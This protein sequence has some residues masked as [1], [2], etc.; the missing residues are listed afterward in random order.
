MAFITTKQ[1]SAPTSQQLINQ[2]HATENLK[3]NPLSGKISVFKKVFVEDNPE[4][5][6]AL[7]VLRRIKQ[8]F[9]KTKVEEVRI[10]VGKHGRDSAASKAAKKQKLEVVTWAGT[11][12]ER[13]NDSLQNHSGLVAIDLDKVPDIKA[14]K[15]KLSASQ[16]VASCWTSS[17]ET[18][19]WLL[20]PVH[21]LPVTKE[22]HKAAWAAVVKKIEEDTGCDLSRDLDKGVN[23]LSRACFVSWDPDMII[24][25]E[26][27]H[28]SWQ[29]EER[30]RKAI[31]PV[32]N[33]DTTA[34]PSKEKLREILRH[35][36]ARPGYADWIKVIAGIHDCVGK[37]IPFDDALLLLKEWSPEE[38]PDEY[39]KKMR[40]SLKRVGVGTLIWM[41][42]EN[43][44]Q[45]A[46]ENHGGEFGEF[47]EIARARLA[48][49]TIVSTESP[50]KHIHP[51][52]HP[53]DSIIA[54]CFQ[55]L[56]PE[57]EGADAYLDGAISVMIA[58]LL[59][60]RVYFL[61]GDKKEYPND[62]AIVVGPAGDRK[63]STIK[64]VERIVRAILPGN[65]FMSDT[66]SPESLF[67]EFSEEEGGMP[68]KVWIVDDANPTLS[69]WRTP[70]Q[71]ERIAARFLNLYDCSS[72]S[73]NYRQNKKKGETASGFRRIDE[74]S[75]S[76]L[77]GATFQIACFQGQQVQAGIARRFRYYVAERLARTIALPQARNH[78]ATN[79]IVQKL[80]KLLDL[81]GEIKFSPDAERLWIQHQHENRAQIER[82]S[83]S[84][85][86]RRH[87]LA[88]APMH[89]L[90]LAIRFEA[91]RW[92]SGSE[93]WKGIIR[94]DTLEWAIWHQAE[95]LRSA[96]YLDE[97]IHAVPDAAEAEILLSKIRRD[98]ANQGG[99]IIVTRSIL[100][101][102]FCAHGGRSGGWKPKDLYERY[103]PRLI[104]NGLAIL[105]SKKPGEVYAFAAEGNEFRTDVA[106]DVFDP[107]SSKTEPPVQPP[108][109]QN[110]VNPEPTAFPANPAPTPCCVSAEE[111]ELIR[112][113]DEWLAEMAK[114]EAADASA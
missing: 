10:I 14:T 94:K 12:L 31:P 22:Q 106:V 7:E 27:R 52:V 87:R 33:G 6:H 21:P 59:A 99:V 32:S 35:I 5:Q 48:E 41:A 57:L 61:W 96:D 75:S 26:A 19:L 105:V 30:N 89:V 114:E 73:E 43:G 108:S 66:F 40:G 67:D 60:R 103:I 95:C 100:T 111:L 24:N 65:A 110:A 49:S 63:S 11:F 55:L 39:S 76:V 17:T 53:P 83:N 102:K 97:R 56:Q 88:S 23:E 98:F 54:E 29:I 93:E 50:V 90:K 16:H 25:Q 34:K 62:F 38:S 44:W 71:G 45:S 113:R 80:R 37:S 104:K 92:A 112:M 79:K 28:V 64:A 70:P 51:A 78:A 82:V 8:G 58:G 4:T 84:H 74:T 1:Q 18:G 85:D 42:R 72:L 101:H 36:P 15:K 68:D 91:A 109:A 81:K 86:A 13:N 3:P 20:V 69:Y 2:M 47:V 77:F 107:T 9:W 46:L